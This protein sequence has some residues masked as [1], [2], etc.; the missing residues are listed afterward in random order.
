MKPRWASKQKHPDMIPRLDSDSELESESDSER[1]DTF[2]PWTTNDILTQI[3]VTEAV[4]APNQESDS[5][6]DSDTNLPDLTE[7]DYF[8][9]EDSDSEEDGE[10][11]DQE[12]YTIS[13]SRQD[14]TE[15]NGTVIL[16]TIPEVQ[17][18]PKKTILC[19]LNSGSSLSL[20]NYMFSIKTSRVRRDTRKYGIIKEE[21]LPL[22]QNYYLRPSTSAVHHSTKLRSRNALI[23]KEGGWE[24]WCNPRTRP[25]D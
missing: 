23:R 13:E 18:H 25:N 4:E 7:R 19:L 5:E 12:S 21:P 10:I 8:I 20:L 24:V 11:P 6:S 9:F 15:I 14:S 22:F 2:L 17:S 1:K 3:D 16:L